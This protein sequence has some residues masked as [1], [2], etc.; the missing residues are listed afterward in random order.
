MKKTKKKGNP[1]N[2]LP[3][4]IRV[5]LPWLKNL[6]LKGNILSFAHIL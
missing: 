5:L 2:I 3:I 1:P 4:R 6:V